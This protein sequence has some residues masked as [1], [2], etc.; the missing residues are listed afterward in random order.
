MDSTEII[1]LNTLEQILK[2]L[3]KLNQKL[4][5]IEEEIGNIKRRI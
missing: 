2:E 5:S 3:C 4:S 1:L